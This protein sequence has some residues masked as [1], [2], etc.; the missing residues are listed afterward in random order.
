MIPRNQYYLGQHVVVTSR[1]EGYLSFIGWI[2]AISYEGGN[3]V[4]DV[5]E[6]PNGKMTSGPWPESAISGANN[7]NILASLETPGLTALP[8]GSKK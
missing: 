3:V 8:P 7:W 5:A 6:K 1:V 2:I 4:Y